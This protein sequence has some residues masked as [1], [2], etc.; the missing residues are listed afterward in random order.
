MGV[1]G[2]AK[3][4]L[5]PWAMGSKLTQGGG[6]GTP[7]MEGRPRGQGLESPGGPEFSQ[8]EPWGTR[9]WLR[10]ERLLGLRS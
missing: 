8:R 1:R 7:C 10:V 3:M 4:L 5:Q 6:K 2:V 9:G